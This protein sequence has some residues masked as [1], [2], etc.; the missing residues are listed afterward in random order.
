MISESE[1]DESPTVRSSSEMLC[2]NLSQGLHAAAQPLTILRAILSNPDTDQMSAGELRELTA[3]SAIE[4]ERVCKLFSYLRELV[5]AENAK[6]HLSSTPIVALLTYAVDGVKLLYEEDGI[7][8]NSTVPDTCQPVFIDRA[9]TLQA[10]S[11]VLL[12]AHGVSQAQD[13]VEVIVTCP[14]PNLVQ[15]VVRNRNSHAESIDA[16]AR[17]GLAL[18]EANIRSQQANFSWC[19]GPFSVRIELPS[20][21]LMSPC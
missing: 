21:P 11:S 17:L 19:P 5:R 18:A 2:S 13:T 10:L 1:C 3:T 12:I 8:L 16:E 7:L 4:V 9:R 15:V 20:A 6:P 14:T